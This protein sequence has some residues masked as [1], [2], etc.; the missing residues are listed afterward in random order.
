MMK[1]RNFHGFLDKKTI[2]SRLPGDKSS[3]DS[4]V[5]KKSTIIHP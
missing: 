5:E 1:S 2:K 3:G 4:P